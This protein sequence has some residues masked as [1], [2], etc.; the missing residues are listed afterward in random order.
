MLSNHPL[1]RRALRALRLSL[2]L[3]L[4]MGCADTVSPPTLDAVPTRVPLLRDQSASVQPVFPD[5][6]I[7]WTSA[8]QQ[9]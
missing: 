1:P 8:W 3:T 9:I 7:L 2:S 5:R 6:R 4:V